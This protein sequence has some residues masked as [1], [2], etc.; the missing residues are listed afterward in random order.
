VARRRHPVVQSLAVVHSWQEALDRFYSLRDWETRPAGSSHVFELSRIRSLLSD[1]G[2]PHRAWPAV[3]VAGTNG[4]GS[5]SAY[6][7]SILRAAGYRT[8]LFTSPHLHTLRERIRVGTE[9]IP[10]SYAIEW[11]NT[12]AAALE[13]DGGVN[14]CC[15][16][17]DQRRHTDRPRPY[18]RTGRHR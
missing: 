12:H 4:K 5:T 9:L 10:A 2:N 1:L 11:L 3:H 8:G 15:R 18:A 14:E 17:G 16:I 13:R 7:A 6:L